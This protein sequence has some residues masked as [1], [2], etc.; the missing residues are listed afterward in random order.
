MNHHYKPN[1]TPRPTTI[2]KSHS[3]PLRTSQKA[4][5]KPTEPLPQHRQTS[6][7]TTLPTNSTKTCQS[8]PWSTT[9]EYHKKP[10]H[11]ENQPTKS[12]KTRHRHRHHS[13]RIQSWCKSIK[14]THQTSIQIQERSEAEEKPNPSPPPWTCKAKPIKPM[15][16]QGRSNPRPSAH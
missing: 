5:T 13:F 15:P 3:K 8:K 12:T 6:Q 4:Y 10:P 7:Q 16:T 2:H 1:K 14:P 11:A 9:A